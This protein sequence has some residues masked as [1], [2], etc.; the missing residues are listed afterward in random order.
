[1]DEFDNQADFATARNNIGDLLVLPKSFNAAYGDKSY[2]EKLV[3]YFSQNILA[4]TLNKQKYTTNPGFVNFVNTSGLNFEPYDEF[5]RA[6]IVKRADLYR[7]IL[8]YE[9]AQYL[10]ET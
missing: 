5:K 4:Q 1:M 8:K 10:S 6:N 9:F 3:Q 7:G 2:T